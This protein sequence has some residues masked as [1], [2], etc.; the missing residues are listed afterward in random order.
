MEE[1]ARCP[2]CNGKGWVDL[3]CTKPESADVCQL[4]N[5]TG[6]LGEK[7]CTGCHGTG[8]IEV[9]TVDQMKCWKCE[10]T[11]LYPVPEEP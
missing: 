1:S 6:V 8:R 2:E 7:T 11:G 9:R 3:R 10:G 4:C 5:G